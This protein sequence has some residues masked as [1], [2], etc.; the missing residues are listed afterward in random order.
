MQVGFASC[1]RVPLTVTEWPLVCDGW[2]TS[3]RAAAVV[4]PASGGVG[5]GVRGRA[6]E[7]ADGPGQ[8]G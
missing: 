4:V 7:P 1:F 6:V 5:G 8:M 3:A 2:G